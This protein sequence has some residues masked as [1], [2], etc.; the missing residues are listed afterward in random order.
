[1]YINRN[2]KRLK[3]HVFLA[4][5]DNAHFCKEITSVYF[6][7]CYIDCEKIADIYI[8]IPNFFFF[9]FVLVGSV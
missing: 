4:K 8:Y 2:R 5:T 6:L 1:M 7:K 9:V 3:M